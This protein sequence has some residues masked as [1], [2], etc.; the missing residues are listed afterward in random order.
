MAFKDKNGKV[1]PDVMDSNGVKL[2]LDPVASASAGRPKY[3]PDPKQRQQWA[4]QYGFAEKKEEPPSAMQGLALVGASAAA[5]V[6]ASQLGSGI[7]GLF[8]GGSKAAQAAST[9]ANSVPTAAAETGLSQVSQNVLAS[10]AGTGSAAAEGVGLA[11]EGG[12]LA[13]YPW[14]APL[15]LAAVAA[16]TGYEAY[17]AYDKSKGGL[18]GGIE[19]WKNSNPLVKYNPVLAW[20]PFA[21]GLLGHESTREAAQRKTSELLEKSNDPT[22][23]AYVQG[24]REQYNAAPPD[25]SKPFAGKY[26]T[27]E[28]YRQAGLEAPD[29][30]GAY[31]NIKAFGPEWA[32]LDQAKR[33]EVTQALINADLYASK[34]GDVI[35][36]DEEKAKQ[37]YADLVN[38]AAAAQAA[39]AQKQQPKVQQ[40]WR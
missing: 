8:S 22:Y 40:V 18:S 26:G 38:K 12:T 14:L 21:G 29:L 9:A 36:T 31:G 28:E 19:G 25:P 6:L 1:W 30:T 3:R 27:F 24:M 20:A 32:A 33:E 39:Q 7:G 15:G 13:A 2:I 16:G 34:K 11:A 35:L 37:I 23:Q 17:K 4:E 10:Q 5:P